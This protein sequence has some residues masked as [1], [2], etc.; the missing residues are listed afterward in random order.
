MT[1]RQRKQREYALAI[2]GGRCEVCGRPLG[3]HA[4]AAHRIGNTKMNREKYGAY[5][6]DHRFNVGYTC[7]LACN[8]KLDISYNTGAVMALCRRIY[9]DTAYKYEVQE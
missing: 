5:V 8:A 9:S 3:S 1:E 4:Q 2:S 7:S 6:I